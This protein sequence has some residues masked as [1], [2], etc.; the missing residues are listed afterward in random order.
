MLQL[1]PGAANKQT[2]VFPKKKR[3]ISIKENAG[4]S[5]EIREKH[6]TGSSPH[7]G[8]YAYCH[9]QNIAGNVDTKGTQRAQKGMRDILLAKRQRQPSLTAQRPH[10]AVTYCCVASKILQGMNAEI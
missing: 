3:N 2:E 10:C 5:S 7:L 6:K 9:K 1:R 4:E 8:E